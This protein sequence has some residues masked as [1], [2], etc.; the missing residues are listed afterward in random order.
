MAC[1]PDDL[2]GFFASYG[3]RFERRDPR[4]FRTGFRGSTGPYDVWLKVTETWVYFAIN[5]YVPKPEAGH[6]P[7]LLEAILKANH[8]L[9]L[10]KFALDED[11]D[12]LLSVELPAEDFCYSHFADALTALSHYADDYRP[13]LEEALAADR[14]EVV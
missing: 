2:A 12:V 14:A 4:V 7:C 9:N 8:D 1:T 6:G 10:A 11:G 5:P 13:R 3:W